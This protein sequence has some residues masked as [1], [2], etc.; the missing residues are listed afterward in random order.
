LAGCP[1]AEGSDVI[2]VLHSRFSVPSDACGFGPIV[3]EVFSEPRVLEGGF[4]VYPLPGVVNE[5]FAKEVQEELVE[6][7]IWG[8]NVLL[9]VRSLG[10]WIRRL[11]LHL[12]ASWP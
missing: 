11:N 7:C 9:L 8:N 4:G 5:D 12:D 6:D 2:R 10:L 3:G 1:Q